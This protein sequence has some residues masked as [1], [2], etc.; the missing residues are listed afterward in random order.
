MS[1]PKILITRRWP[2]ETL[3]RVAKVGDV[4]FRD[5]DTTMSHDEFMAAA[6]EYDVIMPTVSDKIPAEFYPAAKGKVKILASYGVG[7]NHID[8]DAARANDIAVTNTPDVLTDCTADLAMGLLL[9][10]ARRI[11]EGERETRAGKWEGWRPTHMIGKKVS[12]ATLGI[13]GFGRIGQAMA[14]RA[15]FGFGMK[16]VFQDAWQVPDDIKAAAGNATQLSSINEVAA[17]SDFLSLHCPGG[18]DT[19]KLINAEVFGAMKKGCILVNSARGDVVDEDALFDALDSGKLTAAGLDVFMG[20]PALD[21]RF[22]NYENLVLAPHLGSA[23]DGTRDAMG[24]RAIDNLEAF[25]AGE[26]PR[27]LVS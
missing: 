13:I 12:G 16:I 22:L 18:A 21:P 9:A 23:T 17:H 7:Y 4:T 10:A 5:P 14:K 1:T 20:E 3:D 19:F 26:K 11:G 6:R 25:L 27:D 24:H 8:V 15:H 2:Q